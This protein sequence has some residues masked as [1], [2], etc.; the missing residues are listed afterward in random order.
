MPP[1]HRTFK[2]LCGP[3]L[4]CSSRG[5]FQD[6]LLV[7]QLVSSV[8]LILIGSIPPSSVSMGRVKEDMLLVKTIPRITQLCSLNSEDKWETGTFLP[9][10]HQLVRIN[11]Q[12]S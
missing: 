7:Q 6:W 3:V 4:I 2:V 12:R 10:Q 8:V 11:S 9:L 5:I 1:D